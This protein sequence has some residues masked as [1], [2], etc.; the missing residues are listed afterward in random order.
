MRNISNKEARRK[1]ASR[2]EGARHGTS[3]A[4]TRRGK[5]VGTIRRVAE[6]EG[7]QLPDIAAFRAS[8]PVGGKRRTPTV[9][10]LRNEAPR[11]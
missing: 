5:R 2:V 7:T 4:I 1:F 3:V 11:P 6:N 10:Y 9:I 8:L